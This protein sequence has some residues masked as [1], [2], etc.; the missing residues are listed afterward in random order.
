M[1]HR[2][3]SLSPSAYLGFLVSILTA[4]ADVKNTGGAKRTAGQ[5]AGGSRGGGKRRRQRS[6]ATGGGGGATHGEEPGTAEVVAPPTLWET[7]F[8]RDEVTGSVC[9][10]LAMIGTRG[11]TL[12]EALQPTLLQLL[13][14]RSIR[15]GGGGSAG[16]G[17]KKQ[18]TAGGRGGG[19]VSVVRSLDEG[20]L[21]AVLQGQRAAMACVLCCW[22]GLDVTTEFSRS[23]APADTNNGTGNAKPAPSALSALEKPMAAACVWAMKTAGTAEAAEKTRGARLLRPVLVLVKRWPALLPLMV[24]LIVETTSEVVEAAKHDAAGAA[25]QDRNVGIGG[26]QPLEPILRCLQT[27]VRDQGLQGQLRRRHIG[28]LREGARTLCAALDGSPLKG[29]VVQL[30]ADVDVLGGGGVEDRLD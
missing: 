20:S 23:P 10:S 21:A 7:V 19:D 9:N 18:G 2:R 22:E 29:V 25:M 5:R 6:G 13:R 8:G 14:H 16:K 30:Q 1:H 26:T 27:V 4:S 3:R 12:L 11:G 17:E 28:V 15:Q 24:A